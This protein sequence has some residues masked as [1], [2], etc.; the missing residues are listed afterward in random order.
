MQHSF[1]FSQNG[2]SN[3]E[4]I[5]FYDAIKINLDLSNEVDCGLTELA[6]NNSDSNTAVVYFTIGKFDGSIELYKK[7]DNQLIKLCTFLNHNKLVTI[8]K[9]NKNSS[10][11]ASGSNDYNVIVIDF[12]ALIESLNNTNSNLKLISKYKNK[13]IGHRERI[14]GLSWS[15][16]D[17]CFL[18]SC[19]YD[20]T[21]QVCCCCFQNE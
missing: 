17:E 19:S 11:L 16:H 12:K 8:I 15:I 2:V 20:S 21:V 7:T 10:L 1:K 14:T 18:A 5:N 3:I 9:W 13:L 4:T 6:I